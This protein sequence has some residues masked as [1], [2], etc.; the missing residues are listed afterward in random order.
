MNIRDLYHIPAVGCLFL[1]ICTSPLLAQNEAIN[2]HFGDSIAVSFASG[3]AVRVS[4]S[5]MTTI[6]GCAAI[7]DA[8][9][10]LLFYTNGGGRIPDSSGQNPG[11]IWNRNNQPMYDMMGTQGGGFS[12][13][14][15]SIIFPDPANESNYYLFTM[16]ELEFDLGG[17][18]EGQPL[19]RGLSYFYVDMSLNGGLGG[20]SLA[21]Q[22][23]FVPTYEGLAATAR[24]DQ[25]GYWVVAYGENPDELVVV[26]VDASGVGQPQVQPL[27]IDEV[28]GTI[29][30][31]PDG[32]KIAAGN[33][34][35]EFDNATGE[36]GELIITF[37]EHSRITHSFTPDSRFYYSSIDN[38]TLERRLLRYNLEEADILSSLEFIAIIPDPTITGQMQIG[39]NGN[40]YVLEIFDT[41]TSAGLSEIVCP[42]GLFPTYN[43]FVLDLS[44]TD[45]FFFG[46]PNYVDAIFQNLGTE[47]TVFLEPIE[48]SIC[49]GDTINARQVGLNYEWSTE[50]GS[51]S[52]IPTESGTYSVTIS[53]EC[54]VTID[55]QI[56]TVNNVPEAEIRSIILEGDCPG[57]S[58]PFYI[59]SSPAPDSVIWFDS[60][61]IDTFEF[62]PIDGQTITATAFYACGSVELTSQAP[63]I[64]IEDIDAQILVVTDTAQLCPGD[65]VNLRV[66][67]TGFNS[68]SWFNGE[69]SFG[70]TVA[71]VDSST[72]YRVV[73]NGSCNTSDTLVADLDFSRCPPV[74]DAEFPDIITPNGDGRN[75]LFRIFSSCQVEDYQLIV[76][77]RWGQEV[78]TTSDPNHRGWD[79]TKNGEPQPMEAY[80]YVATFRFPLSDEVQQRDGQFTLIR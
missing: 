64:D 66:D 78:F 33:S 50:E 24:A 13:E 11:I 25:Q 54:G 12:A 75:D 45:E 55:E 74:C 68:V 69:E 46:L 41:N 53:T 36:V 65:E 18:V 56:V 9:G 49:P 26:G 14:Q 20:V 67:G 22:R 40:L 70:I 48:L 19:G 32:S 1:S 34:L 17:S 2:W 4:P 3:E 51:F 73:L 80:L 59:L 29:K 15:S 76:F 8:A 57:D 7:S 31:S 77:N 6:E 38:Q 37:I 61:Q 52:I 16:E 28:L 43:R 47:D 23:V 62:A 30:I 10:N 35:F 71:S 42:S 44:D 39:P 63:I 60:I 79:G 72:T 27:N 21:D 5:S 58:L